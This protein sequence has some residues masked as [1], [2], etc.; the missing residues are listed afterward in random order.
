[1]VYFG[2]IGNIVICPH[3]ISP[4]QKSADVKGSAL[5][6]K[7]YVASFD[8]AAFPFSPSAPAAI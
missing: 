5:A 2:D 1:M 7:G 8:F 3:N 6:S 4:S